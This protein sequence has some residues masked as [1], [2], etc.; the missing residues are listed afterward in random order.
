MVPSVVAAVK[1]GASSP[2]RSAM[3]ASLIK[4]MIRYRSSH[5]DTVFPRRS[6]RGNRGLFFFAKYPAANYGVFGE[7]KYSGERKKTQRAC[8]ETPSLAR[9][10]HDGYSSP[11]LTLPPIMREGKGRDA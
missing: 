6:A 9:I 4:P 11:S 10:I 2:S 7:G 8:R 5:H 3:V 1:F